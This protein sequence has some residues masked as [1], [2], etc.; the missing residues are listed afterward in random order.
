MNKQV[1]KQLNVLK[2]NKT[3]KKYISTVK[4]F[5]WTRSNY[6]YWR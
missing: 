2:T 5:K 4:N 6:D 1:E 3:Y